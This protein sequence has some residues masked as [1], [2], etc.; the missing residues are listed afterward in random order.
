MFQMIYKINKIFASLI[1]HL[2][3]DFSLPFYWPANIDV[4]WLECTKVTCNLTTSGMTEFECNFQLNKITMMMLLIKPS[5]Y[6]ITNEHSNKTSQ[7][8]NPQKLNC[9]ILFIH[10]SENDQSAIDYS[11]IWTFADAILVLSHLNQM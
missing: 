5:A 2:F 3:D 7:N 10:F 11:E 6:N 8:L 9:Q 4:Q 1:V